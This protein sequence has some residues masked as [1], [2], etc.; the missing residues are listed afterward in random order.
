MKAVAFTAPGQLSI[1]GDWPEPECGPD[2]VIVQIRGVGLCG[3][4]LAVYDGKSVPPRVPWI[5]GHEG[6]GEIVAAGS[7]VSDRRPG[8]RVIIE[9]NVG[10]GHC[11]ACRRGQT[12]A[13]ETRQSV[14]YTMTGLLAERVAVPAAYTWPVGPEVSDAAVA[15]FEPLAVA[16]NAVRRAGVPAGT[17]CL[18]VGAGSVGQLVCQALLA[19]GAKPF[20]I[21]PHPG[22]LE[23]AEKLG[24]Q[25][26]DARAG[27]T[28]LFVFETSGVK[29]SWDTAFGALAKTGL[30]TVIGF[31]RDE[32]RFTPVDLV[33]G[34]LS[35]RG[36][37]IYDHP[38]D[39][40]ATLE[41]V[42]SGTLVP[43]QGVQ[44]CYPVEETPA[45]F[46][47]VRE[48]PGKTWI[49]F[50]SWYAPS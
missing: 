10:C 47:A 40:E 41:A 21:E 23:Q 46:A 3:T 28:Y 37:L 19:E 6:G 42:S 36:H 38:Q 20:V 14:G 16:H 11:T 32:V 9:P 7:N 18:V 39:F 34:Q 22:R 13:C 45:A 12:S 8:Q 2:D 5:I 48:I 30:L 29:A 49:D 4:D 33:R 17:D 25:P 27:D 43:E 50:A 31:N 26:A 15:C 1:V 24:A 35:I 44:A